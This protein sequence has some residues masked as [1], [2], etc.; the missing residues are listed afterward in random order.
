MEEE[1][2]CDIWE[3]LGRVS[4][5]RTRNRSRSDMGRTGCDMWEEWVCVRE[6]RETELGQVWEE[7]EGDIWERT[8]A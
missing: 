7:R 5:R 2:E 3:E 1:W 6:D 4:E 8:S